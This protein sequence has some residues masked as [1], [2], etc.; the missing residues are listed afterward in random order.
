MGTGKTEVGRK[1]AEKLKMNFVDMDDLI[2]SEEGMKI[3]EIFARF[4][5]G[6][7]RRIEKEIAR[8]V[9]RLNNHVI[10]TGGGVVLDEENLNNFRKNGIL[11]CLT[12]TPEAIFERTSKSTHRPLLN[13][14]KPM[15]KIKKLLQY[16]AP[17]YAKAQYSVDTT[18]LSIQ[19]VA[20]RIIEILKLSNPS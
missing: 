3:S 5:E 9:S 18:N 2:E 12:A 19:E 8:R 10:A 13:E 14:A 20:D 7:F 11:I 1:L 15:E 16:R 4:G 6:Y 17:F